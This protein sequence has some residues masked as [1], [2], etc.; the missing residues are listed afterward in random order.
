MQNG[1]VSNF[2]KGMAAGMIAGAAAVT[3]GKMMLDNNRN[4]SKGSGKALRAVSDFMD[5]IHTMFK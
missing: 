1:A 4:M 3:A 5:G 2:L